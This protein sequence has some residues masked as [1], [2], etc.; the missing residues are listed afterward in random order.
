MKIRPGVAV[1]YF[2]DAL[3]KREKETGRR[4]SSADPPCTIRKLMKWD[5]VWRENCRRTAGGG[6]GLPPHLE[7]DHRLERIRPPRAAHDHPDART[8]IRL[9]HAEGERRHAV[10][11]GRGQ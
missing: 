11:V 4:I 10:R 9:G 3:P 1:V 7:L 6:D 5:E 8:G 2:M